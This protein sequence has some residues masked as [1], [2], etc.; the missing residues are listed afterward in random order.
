MHQFVA[1]YL[2]VHH[3]LV[4]CIGFRQCVVLF[5]S[6]AVIGII[7]MLGSFQEINFLQFR[8]YLSSPFVQCCVFSICYK[9]ITEAIGQMFWII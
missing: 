7:Y 9:V 6:A 4:I 2:L 1:F 3:K 5:V 8:Y